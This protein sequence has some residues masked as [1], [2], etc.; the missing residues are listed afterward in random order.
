M[1]HQEKTIVNINYGMEIWRI[2]E[3]SAAPRKQVKA[4]HFSWIASGLLDGQQDGK[5]ENQDCSSNIGL[6]AKHDPPC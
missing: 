4:V 6:I 2:T 1:A 5:R 3:G